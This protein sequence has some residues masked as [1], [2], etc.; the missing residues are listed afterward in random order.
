[1]SNSCFCSERNSS[2]SPGVQRDAVRNSGAIEIAASALG[3]LRVAVGI[4]DAAFFAH[5]LRPPDRRIANGR[6]QFENSARL[7]HQ[8][9]LLQNTRHGRAHDRHVVLGGIVFHLGQHF[10]ALGQHGV[11]IVIDWPRGG[12]VVMPPTGSAAFCLRFLLGVTGLRLSN[13]CVGFE[14]TAF[15]VY[16]SLSDRLTR[17][18]LQ[19]FDAGNKFLNSLG[20]PVSTGKVPKCMGIT[21]FGFSRLIA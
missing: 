10:V 13:S 12:E 14:Q 19:N 21:V 3:I 7:D 18:H 11:E 16:G 5:R 2:A 17:L 20:V 15:V 6:A 1:M 9:Q 8:G 4:D